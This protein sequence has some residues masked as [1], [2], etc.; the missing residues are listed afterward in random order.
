MF[1]QL[2]KVCLVDLAEKGRKFGEWRRGWL[3]AGGGRKLI[4]HS[5]A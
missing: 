1:D 4:V 5:G 3:E 2:F